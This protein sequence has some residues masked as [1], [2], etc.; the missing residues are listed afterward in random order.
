MTSCNLA[1]AGVR[2]SKRAQESNGKRD[3][4]F[5]DRDLENRWDWRR[6]V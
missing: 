2:R 1:T 4:V 6:K 5:S 3:G